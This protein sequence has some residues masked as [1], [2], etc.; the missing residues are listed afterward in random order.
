MFDCLE[1]KKMHALPWLFPASS[2]HWAS[3]ISPEPTFPNSMSVCSVAQLCPTLWDPLDCSPPGSSVRGILQARI[4]EW[5]AISF[6]RGSSWPRDQTPTSCISCITP[7]GPQ[8][9]SWDV[10]SLI[11]A[12]DSQFW[13]RPCS[14]MLGHTCHRAAYSP[15]CTHWAPLLWQLSW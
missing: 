8:G 5:V 6:F 7:I 11:V 1:I 2:C 13:W 9:L 14:A 4:L 15:H 10:T 3:I 12:P